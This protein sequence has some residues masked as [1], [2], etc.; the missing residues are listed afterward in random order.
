MGVG[1]GGLSREKE[2]CGEGPGRGNVVES[3][4][5]YE[6]GQIL[7]AGVRLFRHRE[8]RQPSLRELAE[9]VGFSLESVHHLCNRLEKIG[10]L[11]RIRGA[12]EE[13]VGLLDPLQAEVLR[14]PETRPDIGEEVKKWKEQREHTVQE[15]GKRFSADFGKKEKEDLFS[16]LE[17]RIRKGGKEEKESPLDALFRQKEPKEES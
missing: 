16:Q 5:V 6:E 9:F 7:M 13:R 17:G 14:G 4:T 12:F 15:V 10:A 1:G 2:V 3:Y 8:K 11:E